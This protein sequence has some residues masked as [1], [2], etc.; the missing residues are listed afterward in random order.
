MRFI[1]LCLSVLIFYPAYADVTGPA[2]IVD[3]DTIWIGE[4]KIRLAFTK[5]ALFG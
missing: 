3:G 1:F 4:T 5:A 2:R